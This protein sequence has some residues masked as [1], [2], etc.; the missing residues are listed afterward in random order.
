MIDADLRKPSIHNSFSIDNKTGLTNLLLD[1]NLDPKKYIHEVNNFLSIITSG[2]IKNNPLNSLETEKVANL[3]KNLKDS[4]YYDLVIF[5]MPPILG[6]SDYKQIGK[7]CDHLLF[8]VS[9]GYCKK[10]FALNALKQLKESKF[11]LTGIITNSINPKYSTK[12]NNPNFKFY[13]NKES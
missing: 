1:S 2:P 6:I 11:N 7:Y 8:L 10:N 12:D 13:M 5:D 4:N 3:F 9:I